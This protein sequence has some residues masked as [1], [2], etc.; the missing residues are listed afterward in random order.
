MRQYLIALI[1]IGQVLTSYSFCP[2]D[3]VTIQLRVKNS[4]KYH[5]IKLTILNQTIENI[6]PG[7]KSDYILVE[8]FYPSF[9]VDITFVEKGRIKTAPWEHIIT[10]PI[11]NVGE[12]PIDNQKNTL[13]IDII[14]DKDSDKFQI[15]TWVKK[16]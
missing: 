12:K 9:K 1:F 15:D 11:D 8:P 14:Q 7:K 10:F 13:V 5:I 16:E 6:K 2:T 4:S 3:S